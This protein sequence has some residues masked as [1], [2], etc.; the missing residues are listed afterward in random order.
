[1]MVAHLGPHNVEFATLDKE[2]S[3]ANGGDS[4]Y[5]QAAFNNRVS[6]LSVPKLI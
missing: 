3:E 4:H 2:L 5:S 1:M 6:P